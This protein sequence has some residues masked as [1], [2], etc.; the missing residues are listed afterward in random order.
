MGRPA[1]LSVRLWSVRQLPRWPNAF[2][3][4]RR[5][6]GCQFFSWLTSTDLLPS[7]PRSAPVT[8]SI[9]F[10]AD[11]EE[12]VED[13]PKEATT[14]L[15]WRMMWNSSLIHNVRAVIVGPARCAIG[16]G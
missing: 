7:L 11:A 8:G 6:V 13:L 5:S 16:T 12:C 14:S 3:T 15:T 2:V 10:L 1:R 4:P 9:G